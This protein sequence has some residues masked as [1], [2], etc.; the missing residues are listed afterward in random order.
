MRSIWRI[1]LL[2]LALGAVDLVAAPEPTPV[3]YYLQ[4]I[5]GTNHE[6]P[7]EA[8]FRPVGPKLKSQLSSVFRWERYWEVKRADITV[9][10]GKPAQVR[11]SPDCE[12]QLEFVSA[13]VR[14]TRIYGKGVLVTKSRRNISCHT[15]AIH[16]G[17]IGSGGSWFVV[18]REDAPAEENAVLD[19]SISVVHAP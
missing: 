13:S 17:S 8:S 18:V 10:A 15:P 3:H 11:L 5:W 7:K 19:N 9:S 14:E 4:L 16:G 12:V 1:T 6:K 2:A